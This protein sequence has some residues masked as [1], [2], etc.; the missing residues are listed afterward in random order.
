VYLW[1][2]RSGPDTLAVTL[3]APAGLTVDSAVR[4]VVLPAF[5]VRNVFF[6]LRG[7]LRPG[8]DT[9]FATARSLSTASGPAQPMMRIDAR[10]EFNLGVV[11]HEYPHIP[12]QQF[13]RF[14]NDRLEAVDLR[15]P[16]RLHVAYVKGTDDVQTPLG[17]LQ[18]K[19]QALDPSLLP[20]VDLSTFTTVLIGADALAND[21]LTGAVPALRDFLRQ[22]GTVVVL[23][24]RDEVGRSGL[25]PY[26]ITFAS[27]AGRVSDPAA[28][29]HVT[30]AR[31]P[32]LNW[33]NVIT[34]KDFE[35]WSGDRARNVPAAFDLRY[36]TVLSMGDA[37]EQPT[38]A[39]ILTARVGK[40]TIVYTSLSIDQQLAAVHPGAARLMINLLAAGLSPEKN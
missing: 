11:T 39:T 16:A 6:R 10:S 36:R 38:T 21:A 4:T 32:L 15:V 28:D 7:T 29:V 34:A 35:G 14:S 33:P 27:V 23:P 12:A 2:A 19:L 3:R 31:S 37:G 13:V 9:I 20:V 40:G 5:G 22:G 30:D 26:P 8:S 18:V 24:G 1:S 17:Q 25:L